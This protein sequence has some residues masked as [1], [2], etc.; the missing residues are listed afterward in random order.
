MSLQAIDSIHQVGV[1][2]LAL[3]P[4][5]TLPKAPLGGIQISETKQRFLEGFLHPCNVL[6]CPHTCV[7]HLPKPRQKQA[8][9]R[10]VMRAVTLALQMIITNSDVFDEDN[11][12]LA[13]QA[14]LRAGHRGRSCFHGSGKPGCWEEDRPGLRGERPVPAGP[15]SNTVYVDMKALRRD[16]VR[17][18]ERGS[19]HS[20]LLMESGKILPGVKVIVAN[21]ETK[22]LLGDSEI[23]VSSP[24]NATGYYTVYGEE[25]LHTD[26]LITRLCF[27]DTVTN[28][29]RTGYLGFLRHTELTDASGE[30]HDALYVVGSLDET[31]ELRG[32][33][34]HPIDI[35]T[36][37]IASVTQSIAEWGKYAFWQ[38]EFIHNVCIH[39]PSAV[40]TC[41][42]LLVV[43]GELEGS[44]QE[45]LDLVALVTNVVL[46][47]HYL[48]VGVVVMGP[49]VIPI[50]SRGE[51]ARMHLRNGFLADQLDPIDVAYNM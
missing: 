34:Y 39:L 42:N 44:E 37:V 38:G 15:D 18:V 1:H 20:L 28:W 35:G 47:E 21:T 48:I 13:A 46:K 25:A 5:N 51:K 3:V 23:W 45:A 11:V 31:L 49:G 16:R 50:S 2:C 24:D 10:S 17:L 30:H 29:A 19:P 8:G 32:M 4:A 22:G 36:S 27:G 7:T 33:R 26:H 41:T 12:T 14:G 43:L 9:R 6:M 40:F